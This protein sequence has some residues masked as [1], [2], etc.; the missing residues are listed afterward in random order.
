MWHRLLA[1]TSPLLIRHSGD[2]YFGA[3]LLSLAC[4]CHISPRVTT[5]FVWHILQRD[6][7]SQRMTEEA[8]DIYKKDTRKKIIY[9]TEDSFL[10][11]YSPC[12]KTWGI[13]TWTFEIPY[14]CYC[15]GTTD[16]GNFP[17]TTL[18]WLMS[19]SFPL[20]CTL[21]HLYIK[22]DLMCLGRLCKLYY[23]FGHK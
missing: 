19:S 12:I 1:L 22:S 21:C 15:G 13:W 10:P 3:A 7:V 14:F 16:T 5:E 6:A 9:C 8:T 17:Q 18:Q 20:L 23:T 4:E 2:V 11:N